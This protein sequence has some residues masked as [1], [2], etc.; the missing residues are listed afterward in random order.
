[1]RAFASTYPLGA[2]QRSPEHPGLAVVAFGGNAIHRSCQ[3][4]TLAEQVE[5]LSEMAREMAQMIEAGWSVVITHGN[6]PQVGN[7]KLQQDRAEPEVPGMPLDVCG[8][9]SQGQIGYL[10]EQALTHEF[11]KR[12]VHRQVIAVLT[13]CLVDPADPAF[14]KPTKPIGPFYDKATAQ[15]L[16]IERGWEMVSDSGRGHRRVVPSPAPYRIVEAESIRLLASSGAVVIA[17]GGGGVPVVPDGEGGYAGVEAVIDK[18]LA[19]CLLAAEIGAD[20]LLLLTEVSEVQ[21]HFGSPRQMPLRD[22]ALSQLRSY[23]TEGHFPAGSMGPKVRAAA[24]FIANGGRMAV[25]TSPDR[26]MDGIRGVVGTRVH[27]DGSHR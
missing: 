3:R 17:S 27:P 20:T 7:I 14:S 16:H 5:N 22:V 19:A 9:M 23:E 1:M 26:M 10:L 24:D 4:G 8:A 12:G 18:D 15:Q 21:V 6:G 25:I 13:R 2:P 11:A